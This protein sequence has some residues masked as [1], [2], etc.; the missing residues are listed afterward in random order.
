M[1]PVHILIFGEMAG[2]EIVLYI[3]THAKKALTYVISKYA[4]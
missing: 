2:F 1:A 3:E 4:I